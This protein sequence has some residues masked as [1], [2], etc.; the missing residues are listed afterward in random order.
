MK[1][2]TIQ[3][4]IIKA[5]SAQGDTADGVEIAE[6]IM[7]AKPEFSRKDIAQEFSSLRAAG[8]IV[9]V[10]SEWEEVPTRVDLTSEGLDVAANL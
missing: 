2:S 4:V 1:L 7:K 5:I 9:G 8:L 6:R 3:R 10:D